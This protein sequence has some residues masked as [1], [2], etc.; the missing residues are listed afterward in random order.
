MQNLKPLASLYSWAG[1][2]ESYLVANPEDR[3]SHDGAYRTQEAD[4]T[5]MILSFQTD[6][7]GQTV[8]PDQTAPDQGLWCLTFH[9]HLLDALLYGRATLFK[10]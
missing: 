3:F 9:L 10:F 1:Q 7:T 6:R 4:I 2:F 8:D 5:V